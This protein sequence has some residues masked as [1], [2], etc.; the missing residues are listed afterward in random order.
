VRVQ[1]RTT[2]RQARAGGQATEAQDARWRF[3]DGPFC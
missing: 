3:S 2:Q 1:Q